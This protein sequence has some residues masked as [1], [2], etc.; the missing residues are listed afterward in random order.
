MPDMGRATAED[1]NG[2]VLM[3][4]ADRDGIAAT[5]R[6]DDD[7]TDEMGLAGLL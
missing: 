6:L 4:A 1:R 5:L 7:S 2:A 3:A